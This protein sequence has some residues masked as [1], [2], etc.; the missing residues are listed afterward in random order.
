M[1]QAAE[2][3]AGAFGCPP[4]R[5]DVG[6][7]TLSCPGWQPPTVVLCIHFISSKPRIGSQVWLFLCFAAVMKSGFSASVFPFSQT[8]LAKMRR[9][10]RT[11]CGIISNKPILEGQAHFVKKHKVFWFLLGS[12][13]QSSLPV[14]ATDGVKLVWDTRGFPAGPT[15]LDFHF[16]SC[17]LATDV[18]ALD[19]SG[20]PS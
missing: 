7:T 14:H 4:T 6:Q 8:R 11:G 5:S 20:T 1:S 13:S 18:Q 15:P 10:L 16:T 3:D 12:F 17:F 2:R 19:S 9:K